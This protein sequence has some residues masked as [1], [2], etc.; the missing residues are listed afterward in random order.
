MYSC[1]CT[2]EGAGRRTM[3]V[4]PPQLVEVFKTY[5][6]IRR[7]A[8]DPFLPAAFRLKVVRDMFAGK[9][10]TEVTKRLMGG[11]SIY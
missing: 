11:C 7:L 10:V 8:T 1:A 6:E 3:L 2:G 9:E 4:M 5:P